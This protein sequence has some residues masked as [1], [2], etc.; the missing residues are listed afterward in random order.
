MDSYNQVPII[1]LK[2][3]PSPIQSVFT[4]RL[5]FFNGLLE[6]QTCREKNGEET[7]TTCPYPINQLQRHRLTF[8]SVPVAESFFSP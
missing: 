3:T 2:L 8:Q 4:F 5:K 7:R 6:R 1:I